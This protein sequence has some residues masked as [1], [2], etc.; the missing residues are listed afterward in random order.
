[1]RVANNLFISHP[2]L[3]RSVIVLC[4]F[5]IKIKLVQEEFVATSS[6]SD[7][8]ETGETP[9]LATLNYL[10]S[11]IDELVWYQRNKES[12]SEPMLRDFNQLQLYMSLV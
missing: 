2:R 1:M 11:L 8:Y 10:Y 7:V 9:A 4:F 6:I 12:L 3:I 5:Q